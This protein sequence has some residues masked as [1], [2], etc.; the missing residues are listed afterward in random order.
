MV[1]MALPAFGIV[2]KAMEVAYT[3]SNKSTMV[4]EVLVVLEFSEGFMF[5]G[6]KQVSCFVWINSINEINH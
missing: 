3:I 6:H 1:S 2:H 5:S 4:Q